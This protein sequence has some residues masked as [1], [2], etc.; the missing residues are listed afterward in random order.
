ML[1]YIEDLSYF[2]IIS[3]W[4]FLIWYIIIILVAYLGFIEILKKFN[5][6]PN[7]HLSNLEPVTIIRPIK[8]IDPELTH[9]LESSFLQHYPSD[10]LQILFCIDDPRDASIPII[11]NLIN[12]YPEIDSK[13]LISK[14]FD[15]VTNKSIDHFGPNPKVNNLSKGFK[16]AHYDIL[17]IMDSN[18]WASP[19]ILKN[20]VKSLIENTNNGRHLPNG[21]NNRKVKLVHHVPLALTTDLNHKN[22][23]SKLDEMFLLTSHSKFYVSLNNLSIAPCVNGKSNLYRR[24]DL[25]KAV[26]S[27]PDNFSPFF[28]NKS[29]ISD[30]HHYS[31]LGPGNSIKLFAR[32]IGEDNMIGIALWEYLFGKTGLTGDCVIQPLSGVDNSINDYVTRRVRWLRVRKY[33]VLMATLIEPSTESIVCGIFGTYSLSTFFFNQWF[34]WRIFSIHMLIWVITDYIQYNNWINNI[35]SSN[36]PWVRKLPSKNW[37]SWLFIWIMRE[38]LALPIWIIAMIGHEIDWR[39]R[40]FRI[41]KDLTAEDI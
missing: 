12:K 41:K 21:S 40:P 18:V 25:D 4:F 13:I 27:I 7:H 32:Y 6:A 39:G 28:H 14:Y 8:G 30:A 26:A 36:L 29:V 17:W 33:M 24:S 22:W 34:N 37:W 11:E 20:S 5:H 3:A 35:K 19:N 31:S 16:Y 9:C 10:K 2:R 1:T 38:I 23:G 15:P